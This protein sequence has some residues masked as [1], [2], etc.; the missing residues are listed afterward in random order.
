M[1]LAPSIS[2]T[3]SFSRTAEHL[4]PIGNSRPPLPAWV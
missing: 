2:F 3:L 4:L 1:V